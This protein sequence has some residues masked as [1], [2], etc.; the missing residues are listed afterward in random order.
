MSD[1]LLVD[2][3]HKCEP[4]EAWWTEQNFMQIQGGNGTC[5]IRVRG[6]II[7]FQKCWSRSSGAN[8][9]LAR[10]RTF[11]VN[12][13]SIFIISIVKIPG[14]SLFLIFFYAFFSLSLPSFVPLILF[15]LSSYNQSCFRLRFISLKGYNMLTGIQIGKKK[16]TVGKENDGDK[17][18]K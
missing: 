17:Y 9:L 4:H 1:P 16:K 7:V 10:R 5:K 8:W 12:L 13:T 15:S 14:P 18:L 6:G 2:I 11:N 3:H